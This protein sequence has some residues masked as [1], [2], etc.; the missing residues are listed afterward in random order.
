MQNEWFCDFVTNFSHE[1]AA[2]LTVHIFYFFQ[3][4]DF[5]RPLVI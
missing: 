5:L 1:A 2:D 3:S 4:M